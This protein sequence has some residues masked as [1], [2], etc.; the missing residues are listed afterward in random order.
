MIKKLGHSLEVVRLKNLL[1]IITA[2]VSQA[3]CEEPYK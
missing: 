3:L 2:T 1:R